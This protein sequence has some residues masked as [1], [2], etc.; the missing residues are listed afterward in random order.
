M[1]D[2]TGQVVV[3]GGG[4]H[5]RVVIEVLLAAGWQVVGYTDASGR[6]GDAFGAVPWL[7]DDA[8]L[9]SVREAGVAH[10]IVALGDNALRGRLAER[11]AALGFRL[12]NAIHPSAQI[13][14]SVVLGQGIAVMAQAAVN[15][16]TAIGDNSIINTGATVDHDNRIGRSV[17]IAPGS[18]LAGYVTVED[19]VLIGVGSVVGRGRPLRIGEGAVVGSGSVVFTDVPPGVTVVGNPAR[20]LARGGGGER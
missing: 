20:P 14:P 12:A 16:A 1:R 13:S 7:G 10:A 9:A 4:G 2:E 8:A 18:H 5:A 17:H 6:P 3:I 11:A 19:R 15:A